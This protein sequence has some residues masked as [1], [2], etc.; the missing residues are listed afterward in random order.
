L[1]DV[2]LENVRDSNVRLLACM[3]DLRFEFESDG[4]AMQKAMQ[5]RKM[6][7]SEDPGPRVGVVEKEFAK[8]A[9][10]EISWTESGEVTS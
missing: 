6:V 2:N 7:T 4:E 10:R 1:A 9:R 8:L 3:E 5:L